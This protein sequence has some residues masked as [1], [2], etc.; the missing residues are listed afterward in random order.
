MKIAIA[1]TVTICTVIVGT[2]LLVNLYQEQTSASSSTTTTT[3]PTYSVDEVAKHDS[4]DD[5]WI[6]IEDSIYDGTNFLASHPGGADRII[7]LCGQDATDG[8]LTQDGQ[9][10]HSSSAR[11]QLKSLQ[12]GTL[13]PD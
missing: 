9:G 12:I 1:I 13:S 2:I 6:I 5:C 10:E 7:N 11:A 8:F 3:L 4:F